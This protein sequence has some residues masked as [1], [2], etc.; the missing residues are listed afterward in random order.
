MTLGYLDRPE[1]T[2][3][4]YRPSGFL[5]TGDLGAIDADGFITIHDRIKEMIKVWAEE[6]YSQRHAG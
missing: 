5:R 2:S 6:N 3:D 4:S 1:E